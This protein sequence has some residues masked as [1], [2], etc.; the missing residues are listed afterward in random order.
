[1]ESSSKAHAVDDVS[2]RLLVE[3]EAAD[4]LRV[5]FRT[6]QAWRVIGDG[7]PYCKIGR[8]VRYRHQDL[9]EWVANRIRKSTSDR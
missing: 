2:N 1:M 4:I 3:K 7:P 6:L 9:L 5:S 8:S